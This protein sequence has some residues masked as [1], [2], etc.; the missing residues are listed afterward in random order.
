[1]APPAWRGALP[2]TYHVGPG[3]AEV[4]LELEFD[5]SLQPAYDVIARLEG[6]EEPDQWVIRGNHHDAWVNG[7]TDPVS[8]MVALL[9]E[10]RAVGEL[11]REGW[12]PRRTLVYAAWDAE[13][14]GL[15]GSTEWAEL[16]AEELRGKAVVYINSDSNSRGFLG[17]GGSHALEPFVWDV[18]GS[19]PDP[20]LGVDVAARVRGRMA[21]SGSADE[22]E[23]ALAGGPLP[24]YPLGSGSDYTPCLQHLG[25][26]S[27][28][29][30]F[31]G[32]G[33]NGQ[34]HSAYDTVDHH[35]R[36]MDPGHV[37]GIALARVAGRLSL[38][39]ADAE[40]LPF[41][42]TPL[43]RVVSGYAGEVEALADQMRA[44]R[45]TERRL[46]EEG[47]RA[48]A[49]R[50]EDP[51]LLPPLPA[52]VPY[53]NFAPLR[54]AVVAL[55]ASSAAFD[56]AAESAVDLPAP[57]LDEVNRFL[58]G[59]ERRLTDD[60]GLPGRPWFRHHVYAPGFYTGYGVKTLPG[61]REAIELRRW[62]EAEREIG[63]IAGLLTRLAA[64]AREAASRLS[65]RD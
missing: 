55:E 28:N 19:V 56:S 11:T 43:A 22:R 3:P 8:G 61:V 2:L 65:D 40:L 33:D 64:D 41:R 16:H 12:R 6:A 57:V 13:E 47:H 38:R 51:G 32:E 37:Y 5:W 46:R 21:V 25:I 45:E 59:V 27:L 7:A 50:P 20:R 44:D 18:A 53:L 63:K 48:A 29:V 60:G 1:V 36:F 42:L 9:E 31:G 23:R 17:A 62:D 58:I 49:A 39:L 52:P 26:A 35:S 30:G 15:L 24:L 14:P 54:N 34:Y 10:A 4:H